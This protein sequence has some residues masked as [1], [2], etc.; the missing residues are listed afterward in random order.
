MV[1]IHEKHIQKLLHLLL[2]RI[3]DIEAEV[4]P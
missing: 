1:I 4:A 2:E 3:M